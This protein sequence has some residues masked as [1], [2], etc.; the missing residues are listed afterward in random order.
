MGN[1]LARLWQRYTNWCDKVGLNPD[2]GRCCIP[3]VH[4]T[5]V[6]KN[7]KQTGNDCAK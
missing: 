1:W 3:K 2:S 7:D 5:P 4:G 6:D